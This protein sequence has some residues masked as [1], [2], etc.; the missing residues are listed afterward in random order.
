[1]CK[2][3]YLYLYHKMNILTGLNFKYPFLPIY[4]LFKVIK[5]ISVSIAMF[6][7]V[8]HLTTNN[9]SPILQAKDLVITHIS[10]LLVFLFLYGSRAG[11]SDSDPFNQNPAPEHAHQASMF[12]I[13]LYWT[14]IIAKMLCQ[15]RA[16]TAPSK[17]EAGKLLWEMC[18]TNS[19][20]EVHR[21]QT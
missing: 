4:K 17:E 18:W 8:A 13:H 14:K 19:D 16:S 10:F 21:I 12:I 20:T 15:A 9:R 6:L 5:I 3:T 1:M 2:V 11:E 7:S